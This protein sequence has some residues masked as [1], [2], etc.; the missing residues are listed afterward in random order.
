MKL[1]PAQQM[2]VEDGF[3]RELLWTPE[4]RAAWWVANPPKAMPLIEFNKPRTADDAATAAFRAQVEEERRL[5][6]LAK[7]DRMKVRQAGKAIDHSKMRWDARRNKFVEMGHVYAPNQGVSRTPHQPEQVQPAP[8]VR[9]APQ[10]GSQ[11]A[12]QVVTKDTAEQI[13]KLN[14]IW[15]PEYEKLRGTGRIVMTVGNVLKGKAKRG[16]EIKWA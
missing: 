7:I 13:A 9:P 15:K 3:P 10:T 6:S 16:E 5:K 11:V 2:M 14:G 8:K 1:T 12:G 4:Q